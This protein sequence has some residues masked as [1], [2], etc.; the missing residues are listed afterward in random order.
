M[1]YITAYD[2]LH[3]HIAACVTSFTKIVSCKT[4]NRPLGILLVVRW[5]KN[6]RSSPHHHRWSVALAAAVVLLLLGPVISAIPV[7][8]LTFVLDE[9]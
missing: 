1:K 2:K 6:F 9:P 5:V 8:P 3:L 4:Q 7:G